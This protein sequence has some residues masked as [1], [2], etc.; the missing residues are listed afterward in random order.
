MAPGLERRIGGS[1]ASRKHKEH[2]K[3]KEKKDKERGEGDK[4]H[5][6]HKESGEGEKHKKHHKKHKKSSS[7]GRHDESSSDS[8]Q[9]VVKGEDGPNPA[10]L[11]ATRQA[12]D[13]ARDDWMV[14]A[15]LR[16]TAAVGGGRDHRAGRGDDPFAALTGGE[17]HRKSRA[18][19]R[20]KEKERAERES[21]KER[22]SARELNPYYQDGGKGLPPDADVER[23]KKLG[24]W[25]ARA[26]HRAGAD[27]A[28]GAAGAATDSPHSG[29]ERIVASSTDV[30]A[31]GRPTMLAPPSDASGWRRQLREAVSGGDQQPLGTRQQEDTWKP[32]PEDES[33]GERDPSQIPDATAGSPPP[34]EALI[35][36][37]AASCMRAQ[38][39]GD[40]AEAAQLQA[41]LDRAKARKAAAAAGGGGGGSGSSGSRHRGSSG[42]GRADDRSHGVRGGARDQEASAGEERQHL[43]M[44][45]RKDGF[46]MPARGVGK[47]VSIITGRRRRCVVARRASDLCHPANPVPAASGT[48]QAWQA[49][50]AEAGNG[51]RGAARLTIM[52]S[53]QLHLAH[54]C[55]HAG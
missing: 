39:M 40:D 29:K 32:Q 6:K 3:Q 26:L 44:H 22:G 14:P 7:H 24:G 10:A 18:A 12:A 50:Q 42:V 35:N 33:E 41:Q 30:S 51:T 49:S 53:P 19:E 4:R 11:E 20:V 37:L 36:D 2:K 25:R 38:L 9:W 34:S 17:D 46:A 45:T 55:A 8:D 21:A 52:L 54:T 5:K 43:L 16:A 31:A 1:D 28:E 13:A 15:T 47:V 27:I 23:A 48:G